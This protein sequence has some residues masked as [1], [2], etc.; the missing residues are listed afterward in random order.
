MDIIAR[1]RVACSSSGGHPR[2]E[3][4]AFVQHFDYIS[5]EVHH[6]GRIAVRSGGVGAGT[7]FTIELPLVPAPVATAN[8]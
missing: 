1:S 2:Q 4:G 3:K 6:D 7:V 5:Y 8:A